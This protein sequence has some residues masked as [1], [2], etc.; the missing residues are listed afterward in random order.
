MLLGLVFGLSAAALFAKRRHRVV[1]FAATVAAVLSAAVLLAQGSAFASNPVVSRFASIT[2]Y[3][4]LQTQTL[5][6]RFYE[7]RIAE[8][9]IRAHPIGGLGWGPPYGAVLLSS[10][11]GSLVTQPR[12][13]M[14]EQ[15]LWIWMRAGIVGLV[16]LIAMLGL[17]V[18]NGARWCRA[19]HG[20]D[21]AWLGAGIVVS[22]VALAASS[23]VAIYLT[24]PD[25]TV[26][27]VGVL[28]LAALTRRDLTRS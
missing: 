23:N 10:D 16:S 5:D 13:F 24:P 19:R 9:R 11:A 28:A 20:E 22:V 1:V 7:N 8:Q 3:S 2:N 25:S 26:P 14:H 15:Y 17:G 12:T 6:D 18:W 21:D 4:Q 27:L